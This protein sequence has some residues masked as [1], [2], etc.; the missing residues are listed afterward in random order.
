MRVIANQGDTVDQICQRHYGRTAGITEQ[1]SASARAAGLEVGPVSLQ[2]LII[3]QT[4][5]SPTEHEEV[6]R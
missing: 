4:G 2:Q 3:R 1:V 5:G 6:T